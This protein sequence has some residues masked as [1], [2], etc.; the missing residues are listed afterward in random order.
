MG[1]LQ[2]IS[3]QLERATVK[4]TKALLLDINSDLVADSPVDLGWFTA[5]F[6][7]GI[8]NLGTDTKP[9]GEPEQFSFDAQL[10]G[11]ARVATSLQFGQNAFVVNSVPYAAALADG[12][13]PQA[14]AGWVD[15]IVNRRVAQSN[16]RRLG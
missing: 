4:E 15:A 12:H 9:K 14:S 11:E 2:K 1:Q 6:I 5:N 13:S 3:I 16:A 8:G 7:P 10:Q